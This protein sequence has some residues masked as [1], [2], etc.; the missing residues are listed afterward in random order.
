MSS[1]VCRCACHQEAQRVFYDCGMMDIHACMHMHTGV[2]Q[3]GQL[4]FYDCGM[5]NELTPNVAKG[6][7]EACF[8]V[9]GGGP[10]ISQVN[11]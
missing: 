3:E 9:F 8:A 10:F 7:K 11:E 5:M 6:F 4:V 1:S 2:N